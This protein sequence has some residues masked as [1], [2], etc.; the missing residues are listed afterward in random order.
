MN[1]FK[2]VDAPAGS[3]KTYS[4]THFAVEQANQHRKIII[5]QPTKEL[6]RQTRK[7]IAKI[8]PT[9]KVTAIFGGRGTK[10]VVG[11]ITRHLTDAT[12]LSGEVVLITHQGLERLETQGYRGA[13]QLVVDEIPGVFDHKPLTIKHTHGLVTPHLELKS[14]GRG[15]SAVEAVSSTT[16]QDLISK[17]DDDQNIATFKDVL[18]A[19]TDP[20]RVVCVV[21]GTWNQLLA[22][23]AKQ[24]DFFVIQR[25]E[26]YAGWASVTFM[27]A[28]ALH[29]EMMVIWPKLFTVEFHDHPE[30]NSRLRYHQHGNG[31]RLTLH[32]MFD[33]WSKSYADVPVAGKPVIMHV[34]K[35]VKALFNGASFL[36]GANKENEDLFDSAGFLPHVPHGLNAPAFAGCNNVA[37]LSATNRQTPSIKFL[38]LL[39]LSDHQI[40]ATLAHQSA[41][42]AAMRCSL[43]DPKAVEDVNIVVPTK[44][45]AHW[46]AER[47]PGSSIQYLDTGLDG[48]GATGRPLTGKVKLTPAEK[49][50]R[51]R[52]RLKGQPPSVELAPDRPLLAGPPG[53]DADEPPHPLDDSAIECEQERSIIRPAPMQASGPTALPRI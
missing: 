38:R 12:T 46:I 11:A 9:V 16:I 43:R 50:A 37:L 2:Y 28:N 24:C 18:K 39:G 44:A 22:G 27:G 48:P 17:A 8:D 20:N 36:W 51:Y 14:L 21:D 6:I 53:S 47:F 4:L 10:N 33:D 49:Q 3:G 52:A 30:L 31:H 42:Q 35:A 40:T 15:M 29:T 1:K 23:S 13:W 25:P 32:Y 45:T 34:V 7:D 19:V 5:A 26:S 41:Y